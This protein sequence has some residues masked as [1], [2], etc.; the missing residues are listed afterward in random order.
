MPVEPG[1]EVVEILWTGGFDSTFR[2]VQLSRLDVEI[3]PYYISDN[4]KSEKNELKAISDITALL[5][6]HDHTHCKFRPLIYV[7]KTSWAADEEIT[8]TYEKMLETDFFGSQYDWLARFAKEHKGIELSVH[9]DDK[10]ILLINKYGKLK[11]AHNE[12]SGETYV[13]DQENSTADICTLFGHFHFPLAQYT[14]LDMKDYYLKNGYAA[15]M[16]KT[17]FCHSPINNKP[18]GM[19]NPCKYT[20]EEGMPERFSRAAI[21][22][23]RLKSSKFMELAMRKLRQLKKK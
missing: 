23:Y 14:K 11:K 12:I 9:Q 22:R 3:Q 5:E 2:V 4:R 1:R 8:K 10:A 20:I 7:D 15:V 6:K 17:W 16:D 21:L 19:C 18:C 13:L